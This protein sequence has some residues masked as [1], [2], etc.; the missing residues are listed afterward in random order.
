MDTHKLSRREILE[1]FK[2][3]GIRDLGRLKLAVI[4]FE[5]YQ[6]D[7]ILLEDQ[8]RINARYIKNRQFYHTLNSYVGQRRA[9][10]R[11]Y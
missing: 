11:G 7:L 4:Q 8:E 1:G 9:A 2:A 3:Q 5:K 6:D 10:G